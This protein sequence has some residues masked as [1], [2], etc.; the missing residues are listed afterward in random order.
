MSPEGHIQVGNPGGLRRE[1]LRTHMVVTACSVGLLFV[2]LVATL[3]LRGDTLRLLKL[4]APTV[5]AARLALQGVNRSLVELR[6]WTLLEQEHFKTGRATA[7]KS[8]IS[9]GITALRQLSERWRDRD[10]RRRL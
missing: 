8:E 9:P 5:S 2:A 4:R 7:W 1:L 6:A 3:W 10:D